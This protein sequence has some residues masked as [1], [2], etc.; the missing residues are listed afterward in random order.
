MDPI[1]LPRAALDLA[2]ARPERKCDDPAGFEHTRPLVDFSFHRITPHSPYASSIG[3]MV[4]DS[5]AGGR[6]GRSKL[7]R[8]LALAKTTIISHHRE[9]S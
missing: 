8:G 2:G 9:Q 5:F 1:Q 6:P 3:K 4:N 7:G